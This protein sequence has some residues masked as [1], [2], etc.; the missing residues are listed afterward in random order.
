MPPRKA[1]LV[2][3]LVAV[4]WLVIGMGLFRDR[5]IAQVV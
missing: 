4:V 5:A 2:E 1:E 3:E